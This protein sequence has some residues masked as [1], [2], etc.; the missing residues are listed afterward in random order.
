[1]LDG[2]VRCG[3]CLREDG[4]VLLDAGIDDDAL[5]SAASRC[6]VPT[7]E[8]KGYGGRQIYAIKSA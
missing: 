7:K 1:M 4:I 6:T 5:P 2:G 3:E 8:H